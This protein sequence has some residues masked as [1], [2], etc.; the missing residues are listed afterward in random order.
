MSQN[1]RKTTLIPVWAGTLHVS[2]RFIPSIIFLILPSSGSCQSQ[3]CNP[4]TLVFWAT[5]DIVDERGL[6][7]EVLRWNENLPLFVIYVSNLRKHSQKNLKT[8]IS[9]LSEVVSVFVILILLNLATGLLYPFSVTSSS[10]ANMFQCISKQ[11][12][13]AYEKLTLKSPEDLPE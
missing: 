12:L 6:P 7:F 4:V 5:L 11:W 2:H 10:V 1:P 8:Y 3:R 13:L 9:L